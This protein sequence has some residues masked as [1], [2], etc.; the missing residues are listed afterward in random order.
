MLFWILSS[1]AFAFNQW[2][3]PNFIKKAFIEIALK[4]EYQKTAMK[5]VKWSKPIRYTFLYEGLPKND[6][7]ERLTHSHLKH[8]SQITEHP[9]YQTDKDSANL[10]IVFTKDKFFKQSIQKHGKIHDQHLAQTSNCIAFFQRNSKHQ[11]TQA[12]V[13]IPVDHAMSRGLLPACIVEE[14]TQIMGL[15]NDS[16]WV[17]PS[18]A[19]D[20]SRLDLLT[21]LDYIMLKILY[22]DRLKAGT[23]LQNTTYTVKE[24]IAELK[25]NNEIK[26]AFRSV[27]KGGLYRYF[28]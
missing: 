25:Q 22:D 3:D 7:I 8:L 4:N 13:I 6:L 18:I 15:P 23:D 26:N 10:N 9:I 21:G 12:T 19:N 28:Q 2:Q 14:T 5:V 17:H 20:A 27:K 24:I 16:D 1:Q 11:I